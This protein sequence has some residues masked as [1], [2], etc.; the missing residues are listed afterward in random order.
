MFPNS[1]PRQTWKQ[2]V[3]EIQRCFVHRPCQPNELKEVTE[4]PPDTKTGDEWA[5]ESCTEMA[6]S[7][8]QPEEKET[9]ST[10]NHQGKCNSIDQKTN[11]A[12]GRLWEP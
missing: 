5:T 1:M 11:A 10:L 9:W 12:E 6:V 3:I 4:K 2:A 7:T 8:E